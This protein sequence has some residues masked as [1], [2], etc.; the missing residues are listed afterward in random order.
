VKFGVEILYTPLSNWRE[1]REN[2][3]SD[4]VALFKSGREVVL[5]VFIDRVR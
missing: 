4:R 2:R 5:S 1:L 3:L